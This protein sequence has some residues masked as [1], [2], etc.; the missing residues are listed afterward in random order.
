VGL[1]G[2]S[3]AFSRKCFFT[4]PSLD[5]IQNFSMGGISFVQYILELQ[6]RRTKAIAKMLSENPTTIW[7]FL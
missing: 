7:S 1:N 2:L 6:I 4:E 5:V 3:N